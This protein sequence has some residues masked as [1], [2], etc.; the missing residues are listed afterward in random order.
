MLTVPLQGMYKS[1]SRHHIITRVYQ[2]PGV[3]YCSPVG[4]GGY[5]KDGLLA[6]E[7]EESAGLVTVQES[8]NNHHQGL[9][10]L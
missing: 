1:R 7:E 6:E 2:S 5:G 3:Y 4:V 10:I 9:F 8:T